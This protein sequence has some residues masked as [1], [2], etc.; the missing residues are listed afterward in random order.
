MKVQKLIFYD[1]VQK[2]YLSNVSW[3]LARTLS[4]PGD[5]VAGNVY[6]GQVNYEKCTITQMNQ[7]RYI[8]S[9]PLFMYNNSSIDLHLNG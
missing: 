7:N 4:R 1:N 3:S 8:R 6:G 9:W 5:K 2:G